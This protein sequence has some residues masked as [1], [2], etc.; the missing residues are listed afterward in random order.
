LSIIAKISGKRYFNNKSKRNDIGFIA[1]EIKEY[2]P[3]LV[4]ELKNNNG[5]SRYALN[6]G[7]FAPILMNAINEQQVMIKGLQEKVDEIDELKNEL[8]SLKQLII[9]NN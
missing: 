2:F 5:D 8:E 9:N 4:I 6:Y 3:E 7:G 1:Q